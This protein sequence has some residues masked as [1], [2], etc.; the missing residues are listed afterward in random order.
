MIVTPSGV[1]STFALGRATLTG[2]ARTFNIT[3]GALAKVSR[4]RAGS[5]FNRV[6]S[7][8]TF[9]HRRRPGERGGS[10]ESDSRARSLLSPGPLDESTVPYRG[11]LGES[12]RSADILCGVVSDTGGV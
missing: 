2:A 8:A 5:L 11:G 3:F 4:A 6:T 1:M 7:F 10:E 12:D 9:Y